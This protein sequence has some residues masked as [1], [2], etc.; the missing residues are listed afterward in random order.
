MDDYVLYINKNPS[1]GSTETAGG[2]VA[3]VK[4]E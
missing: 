3:K 4:R 1:C 2:E